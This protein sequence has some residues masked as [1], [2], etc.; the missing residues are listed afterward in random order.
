MKETVLQFGAGRFL[1]AF[2]DRFISQANE[3]GQDFGRVV[4]VQSTPGER[5]ELINRQPDGY[6]VLVRGLEDGKVIDQPYKVRS[7]SRAM[8]ASTEWASVLKFAESPDLRWVISNTT[9][10][11]YALDASDSASSTPPQSMPAKL[12]QLLYR[13]FQG[14]LPGLGL[15]PCELFEQNAAK[16]KALVVTLGRQ[17]SLPDAWFA[18][19]DTQCVWYENLVDC[20]V[21]RAPEGHALLANDP[22]LICAEPYA[23]WAIQKPQ[24]ENHP[25]VRHP[26]IQMVDRVEPYYLRKVRILNGLHTAM[27]RKFLPQ[28]FATV[29]QVMENKESEAWL[30]A[31]LEEEILPTIA[32]KVQEGPEFARQVWDRFKNPFQEHRL[33]DIT[34]HHADKVR[35]RLATTYQ[36]YVDLFGKKPRYLAEAIEPFPA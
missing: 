7:I 34:A 8:V 31:L 32:A 17:W 18:W 20:I 9:E 26:S 16:L 10:S 15:L 14:G 23:L 36:E 27:A 28:G 30:K 3:A 33:T 35:V 1:R 13:R 24:R 21:T 6:H 19:L 12:T 4:I 11:G 5:A 2:A 25:F 29:R 22:L